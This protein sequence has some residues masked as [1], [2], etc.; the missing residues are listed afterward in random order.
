MWWSFYITSFNVK[1]LVTTKWLPLFYK[2]PLWPPAT[3][4]EEP[5]A[6]KHHLLGTRHHLR[7]KQPCGSGDP[8]PLKPQGLQKGS[9]GRSLPLLLWSGC[10]TC[11]VLC[12]KYRCVGEFIYLAACL[13]VISEMVP[14]VCFPAAGV[15]PTLFPCLSYSGCS[16]SSVLCRSLCVLLLLLV[17][18]SRSNR[19]PV[20]G[21]VCC[22]IIGC[23]F[24]FSGELGVGNATGGWLL[25][26]NADTPCVNTNTP[27]W[28]PSASVL[29]CPSCRLG[30]SPV[31]GDPS[32]GQGRC[33]GKN[34]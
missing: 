9:C 22:V 15:L 5:A 4:V 3:A 1:N 8:D 33:W 17:W 13:R 25:R 16:N 28:Q 30:S 32:R 29:I 11:E 31:G 12:M 21:F 19:S 24:V 26:G 23:W 7:S 2:W 10:G 14:C 20:C 34:F 18:R 27:A 6:F